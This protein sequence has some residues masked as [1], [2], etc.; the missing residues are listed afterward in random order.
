MVEFA[1]V[2]GLF[3]A[4][5]LAIVDSWVWCIES[6][7]ADAAVE[8]AIGIA[9]A[10]P[11]GAPLSVTGDIAGVFPS[12]RGLLAQAM[13]ATRVER[14]SGS[15]GC[16]ASAAEAEPVGAGRIYVCAAG[17]GAGHVTVTVAGYAAS[18]VPPGLSLLGVR[19][20][21]LPIFESASVTAG[22]YTP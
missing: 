11:P 1:L 7:A 13:F 4:M 9:L 21:G 10:A 2:F 19:A 8:Q 15:R 6:G 16:P 18:L 3:L 5:L 20:G 14:W 12:T 22:T 17:D